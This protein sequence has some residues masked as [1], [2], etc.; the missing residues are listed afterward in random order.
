MYE[1][2]K[3]PTMTIGE[4][5]EALRANVI[6]CSDSIIGEMIIDG[7]FPFAVGH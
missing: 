6:P 4:M 7:K 3:R 2:R 1:C 5:C